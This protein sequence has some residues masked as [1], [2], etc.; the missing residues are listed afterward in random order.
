MVGLKVRDS[1]SCL[2]L[3]EDPVLKQG[4][5]CQVIFFGWSLVAQLVDF[6]SSGCPFYVSPQLV[7][8]ILLLFFCDDR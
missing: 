7:N 4:G 2:S 5:F 1:G 3:H 6:Y 8:L